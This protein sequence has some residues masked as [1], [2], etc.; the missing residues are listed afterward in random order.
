MLVVIEPDSLSLLS[1]RVVVRRLSD[2]G[3]D[4]SA[5]ELAVSG[6]ISVGCRSRRRADSALFIVCS[7]RSVKTR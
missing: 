2:V 6:G 3:G 5:D 1:V 7:E 4:E